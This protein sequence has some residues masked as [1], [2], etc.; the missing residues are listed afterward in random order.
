M[1]P[2]VV[3]NDYYYKFIDSNKARIRE[4]NKKINA[5]VANKSESYKYLT[6]NIDA[7]KEIVDID[8]RKCEEYVD[9]TYKDNMKSRNAALRFIKNNNDTAKKILVIAILKYCSILTNEHKYNEELNTR[10]DYLKLN[11]IQYKDIASKYYNKVHKVLLQGYAYKFSSKL[12]SFVINR[13]NLSEDAKPVID[14]N[15]S[16]KRKKKIIAAGKKP[17]SEVEARYYKEHGL[18]YNGIPYVVYKT[19]DKWYEF[20]FI[21][22]RET[23]PKYMEFQRTE[24]INAKFRGMTH[25]EMADAFCKTEE[26]I[27]NFPVD[28]KVKLNILLYKN[29]SAYLNFIRTNNRTFIDKN[30]GIRFKNS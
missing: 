21:G 19:M 16:N 20:R 27:Y 12:G 4:L 26:D 25:Q 9:N 6:D 8:L 13:W 18:E 29:P 24:Y 22:R 15:E 14:Y 30:K 28:I 1:L 23:A 17:Y 7:I 2:D 3:L 5:L 11:Y 10:K